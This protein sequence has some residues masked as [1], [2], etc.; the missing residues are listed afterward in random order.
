MLRY[1]QDVKT[2]R[3]ILFE[4]YFSNQGVV[5]SSIAPPVNP[6]LDPHALCG[7]CDNCLREMGEVVIED[8]TMETFTLVKLLH[9]R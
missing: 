5:T 6:S 9:G 2:C 3:K 1:A 8:I 4:R 7:K